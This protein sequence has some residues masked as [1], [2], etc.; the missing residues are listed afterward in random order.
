L[1]EGKGTSFEGGIRTPCIMR[2]PAGIPPASTCGKLATTMDLLPTIARYAG[3]TLP[4]HR[5]DG[6]DIGSL[7]EGEENAT[8]RSELYC[9]YQG[10]QL[11]AVYDG[12][13]K[14]VFPHKHR[15]YQSFPPGN[16]GFPG[17]NKHSMPMGK[18]LYDL[19]HDLAETVD[20]QH[21]H[22]EIVQRLEAV[23]E[24]ARADLGDDLTGRAGANVRKPG[25]AGKVK[26]NK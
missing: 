23:A 17:Q 15:T 4:A 3:G 9:Y 18:A 11:Q 25:D 8:P 1:R 12:R 13:W 26:T 5:I 2:W 21:E 14:L 6:V 10:N 7:L 16:D 24:Q 22:P 19:G 20:L